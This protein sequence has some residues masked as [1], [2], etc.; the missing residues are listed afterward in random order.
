MLKSAQFSDERVR[1]QCAFRNVM[2]MRARAHETDSRRAGERSLIDTHVLH[3]H[4][5][6]RRHIG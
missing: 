6:G 4:T 2:R 1:A 3:V 5:G